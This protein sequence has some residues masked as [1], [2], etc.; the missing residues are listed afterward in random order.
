MIS[1][2]M[3]RIGGKSTE[4][5]NQPCSDWSRALINNAAF[6]REL[7]GYVGCLMLFWVIGTASASGL[8]I[9]ALFLL[10][11]AV[12]LV[13]PVVHRIVAGAVPKRSLIARYGRGSISLALFCLLGGRA[14]Y[15]AAILVDAALQ[16]SELTDIT[17]H[18][19]S[20]LR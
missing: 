5:G 15:I 17:S 8:V 9:T 20:P 19:S 11:A 16:R 14:C 18:I 13:K 12:E 3:A 10:A 4:F 1:R 2:R 7:L 6:K